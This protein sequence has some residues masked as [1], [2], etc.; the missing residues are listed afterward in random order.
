LSIPY[1]RLHIFH[2]VEF[3]V[4]SFILRSDPFM[5]MLTF[6]LIELEIYTSRE[7]LMQKFHFQIIMRFWHNCWKSIQRLDLMTCSANE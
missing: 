3:P 6:I 1:L 2:F 7:S 4:I 5:W